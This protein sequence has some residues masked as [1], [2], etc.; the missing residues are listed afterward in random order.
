MPAEVTADTDDATF[1]FAQADHGKTV[2]RAESVQ[3]RPQKTAQPRK[4]SSESG[5][6]PPVQTLS[7]SAPLN[8]LKAVKPKGALKSATPRPATAGVQVVL[9]GAREL[10]LS[11]GAGGLSD[12]DLEI[13]ARA[14]DAAA[15]EFG[16][17][18]EEL[19]LN[20]IDLTCIGTSEGGRHGDFGS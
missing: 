3:V 5:K 1:S 14:V 2:D 15:E 12:D 11:I 4:L 20:G 13:V 9:K 10:R 18:V 7:L 8:V 17:S 16:L 6:P 19:R